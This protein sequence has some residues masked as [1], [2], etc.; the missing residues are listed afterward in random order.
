[1]TLREVG[2]GNTVTSMLLT[3]YTDQKL[4]PLETRDTYFTH[5]NYTHS[6]FYFSAAMVPLTGA[7]FEFKDISGKVGTSPLD[8]LATAT[9]EKPIVLGFG[10]DGAPHGH[11]VLAVGKDA[12]GTPLVYDPYYYDDSGKKDPIPLTSENFPGMRLDNTNGIDVILVTPPGA[13]P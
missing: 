4:D 11:Y 5:S 10:Y 1:M 12:S 13:T 6:G 8:E 2:C 3:N 7:G 9:Y